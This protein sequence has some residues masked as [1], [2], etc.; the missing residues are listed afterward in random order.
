[1]K[2]KKQ[3]TNKMQLKVF[4]VPFLGGDAMNEEMNA[5]LRGK[6]VLQ[7]EQKLVENK[8]EMYWTFCV[9]YL[10]SQDNGSRR[11]RE[12]K[13]YKKILSEQA[14]AR[15]TRY[16]ELRLTLSKKYDMPA[17]A[18]FNNEELAGLAALEELSLKSM[19]TVKGI[20]K[21]KVEKF[22]KYFVELSVSD[23]KSELPV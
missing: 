16:R 14:F 22:G 13:D 8:G 4:T 6:N 17:Y 23:E 10:E 15:Y 12:G 5:F 19:E 20:G 18:V 11:D 21:Q 2:I 9:R 3:K 7:V 1:L